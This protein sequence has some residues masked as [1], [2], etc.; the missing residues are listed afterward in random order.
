MKLKRRQ[1]LHMW[2]LSFPIFGHETCVFRKVP[3]VHHL[4]SITLGRICFV[5]LFPSRW[6]F[7]RYK[8][9]LIMKHDH[10]KT[11]SVVTDVLY[12]P[13]PGENWE[14]NLISSLYRYY[15]PTYK[16]VFQNFL[17]WESNLDCSRISKRCTLFLSHPKEV[18]INALI[19][20]RD[21]GSGL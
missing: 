2:S 15:S 21:M 19:F 6:W 16:Q 5:L 3:D 4:L 13:H 17:I 1:K 11:A 20:A 10:W 14:I 9:L 18:K 12:P 8:T 7:S